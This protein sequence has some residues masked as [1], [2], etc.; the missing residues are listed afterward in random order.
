MAVLASVG[1][2]DALVMGDLGMAAERE[3]AAEGAIPDVDILAVGHHGSRYSNSIEMAGAVEPETVIV[4]VGYNTYGHPAEEALD[5][6]AFK[7][8]RIFRTD[9]NG[10]VTI[11]TDQDG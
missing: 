4:S 2:W 11:R 8:A 3:L 1:G 6:L 10:T 5:R 9:L 7:G